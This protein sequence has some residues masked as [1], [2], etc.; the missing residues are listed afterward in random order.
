[1]SALVG[2]GTDACTT[3]WPV[4]E[5]DGPVQTVGPMVH[6]RYAA[7]L[8]WH[9]FHVLRAAWRLGIPWLGLIH[10]LSKLLPDEWGPNAAHRCGSPEEPRTRSDRLLAAWLRH[11]HRNKHH[12]SHWVLLDDNGAQIAVPMPDRYRREM[13]ADWIGAAVVKR[14]LDG[15][16]A[17]YREHASS[18]TLHSE[19]RAWIEAQLG[20]LPDSVEPNV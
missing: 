14:Q 8:L 1:M 9:K 16:P 10:D 20:L 5:R 4:L 18:I 17:W 7:Y 15:V 12:W 11:S 2:P 19:T 6:I 13:L 3:R